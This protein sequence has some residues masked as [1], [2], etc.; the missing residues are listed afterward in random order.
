MKRLILILWVLVLFSQS[1][2]EAELNSNT[3]M[4]KLKEKCM[5]DMKEIRKS[6]NLFL[7]HKEH[8]KAVLKEGFKLEKELLYDLKRIINRKL[9]AMKNLIYSK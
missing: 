4:L 6:I 7:N 2:T 3:C 5:M 1:A 8:S 9:E